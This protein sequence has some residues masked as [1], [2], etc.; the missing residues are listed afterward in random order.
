MKS[1]FSSPLAASLPMSTTASA[2]R[3]R[4]SAPRSAPWWAGL[5]QLVEA[6]PG[7]A[8]L[9]ATA[10]ALL[11]I[12]SFVGVLQSAVNRGELRRQQQHLA[13]SMPT[14]SPTVVARVGR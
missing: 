11:L 7:A 13:A 5:A 6:H 8:L 9:A 10:V 14:P 4:A 12:V 2:S 3:G 1:D